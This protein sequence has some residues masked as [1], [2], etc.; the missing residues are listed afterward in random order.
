M[1]RKCATSFADETEAASRIPEN[2]KMVAGVV[3]T[4]VA[5]LLCGCSDVCCVFIL[6]LTAKVNV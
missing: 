4:L 2:S 3:G 6:I 1:R 5:G